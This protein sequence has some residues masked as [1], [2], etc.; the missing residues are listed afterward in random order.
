MLL[1]LQLK[2]KNIV[3]QNLDFKRINGTIDKLLN[4]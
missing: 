4:D 2:F 1:E 3:K